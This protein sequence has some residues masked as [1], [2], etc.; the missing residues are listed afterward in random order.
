MPAARIAQ[1]ALQVD[2]RLYGFW[3]SPAGGKLFTSDSLS[4]ST[5]PFGVSSSI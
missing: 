4:V 1:S 3:L 2:R 5:R